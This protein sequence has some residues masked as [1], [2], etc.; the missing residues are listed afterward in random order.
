MLFTLITSNKKF[1][2]VLTG[3]AKA[4]KVP[5]RRQSPIAVLTG[6]GVE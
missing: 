3:R 6:S 5:A 4:Y 1:Q 2:L